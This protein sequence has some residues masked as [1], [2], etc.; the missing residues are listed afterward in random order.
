[1]QFKPSVIINLLGNSK[2][3]ISASKTLKVKH[4]SSLLHKMLPLFTS[5]L[6]SIAL[7]LILIF[8]PSKAYGTP[9]FL[10]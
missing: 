8:S 5:F 6:L 2:T 1:M 10:N 7:Y 9:F 3:C 4:K